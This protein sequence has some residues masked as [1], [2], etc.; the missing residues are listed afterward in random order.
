MYIPIKTMQQINIMQEGGKISSEALKTAVEAVKPGISLK[1][2]DSISEDYIVTHGGKPSFKTVDDYR[3]ATCINVNDGIVH[4]IPNSYRL[5]EGDLVSID[6]GVLY[7][8]LH[9]DVSWTVEVVAPGKTA[10][11]E[12]FLDAGKKALDSAIKNC[13]LGNRVGNISNTIQTVIEKAGYTVSLDLVGHGVGA[14]LHEDPYVPG[15]GRKKDGPILKEGMVLAIEVI[16]QKGKPKIKTDADG[17]TLK[18]ADGSLSGLFESTVAITKDD[19][20][21]LAQYC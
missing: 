9:T 15:Y 21:I 11:E 2:L 13:V 7:K 18:T 17:W 1:E 10:K 19:P 5:K 8:G 6:L 20:L 4:G 12:K 16:Y 3:Y 14:D